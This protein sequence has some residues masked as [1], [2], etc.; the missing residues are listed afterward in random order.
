[1]YYFKAFFQLYLLLSY[2]LSWAH[3]DSKS[4]IKIHC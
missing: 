1:M 4:M 2:E 3:M